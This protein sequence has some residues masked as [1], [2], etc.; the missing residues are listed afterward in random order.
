MSKN[1]EPDF[2]WI[3]LEILDEGIYAYPFNLIWQLNKSSLFLSFV[4][5]LL[6][7]N[8]TWTKYHQSCQENLNNYT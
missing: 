8:T 2:G 6:C 3:Y 7:Y 1:Y 5:F 4:L